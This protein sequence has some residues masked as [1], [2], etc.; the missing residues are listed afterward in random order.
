MDLLELGKHPINDANPAGEDARYEP[1]YDELQQEI[2]K[3]SSATAAGAVDWKHVVKVGYVIL[4]TKSKDIKVASY[5][6]VALHHLKEVEGLSTGTQILLDLVN[7]FW[8]TMYPTKKRMRGRFNA[9]SWWIDDAEKYLRSYEGEEISQISADLLQKRLKALDSALADKS[10]D[11]PMLNHLIDLAQRLPVQAPDAPI[12]ENVEAKADVHQQAS[13]AAVEAVSGA[14]VPQSGAPA[15]VPASVGNIGSHDEYRAALKAGLAELGL[16]AEY[17]QA[18]DPADRVGY[19]LRRIVAWL[20]IPALPPNENGKTMIPAP[21]AVERGAIVQQLEGRDFLGALQA[22]ESRVRQ[23][24]FWLDLS[25]LAVEAL[26]SMGGEFNDSKAVVE[27]ETALFVKRLPGIETMTFSDGTP[28]ADAKTK[29]WLK[30]LGRDES[31]GLLGGGDKDST[32]AK[33]FAKA[34]KLAKEKK[35]F[36]A[37]TVLQNSLI[38]TSSGRER[39]TLR[40]GMIRLLTDVNQSSL[41]RA[42][43]EEILEH[44][45]EFRLEQWEP[46]LALSGFNTAYEAL[47]AEGGEEASALAQKT[48]QRIG[49][50]NPALALKINGLN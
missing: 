18:N 7:G 30:S 12:V 20:P 23:Y 3:L 9:V 21:D 43:V 40:L 32:S 4:S 45:K 47:T 2:D 49:R 29:S 6:G 14:P 38:N 15:A 11:A 10:E 8:D 42:H 41:A 24:L 19:R 46:D 28:F 22:C 25:R 44:I 5:L 17:L 37:V 34:S 48:L 39:F 36:D 27:A 16:V 31:A 35:V 50:I 26:D 13:D 1:E 33:A